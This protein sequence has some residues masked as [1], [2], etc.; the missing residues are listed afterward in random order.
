MNNKDRAIDLYHSSMVAF[1]KLIAAKQATLN[2]LEIK[3]E[4]RPSEEAEEVRV[5]IDNLK[6]RMSKYQ[7]GL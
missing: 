3:Y 2:M 4:H 5:E 6:A 7:S 1:E